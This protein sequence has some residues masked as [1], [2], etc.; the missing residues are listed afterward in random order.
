LEYV[1]IA[2]VTDFD[3]ARYRT[4]SLLGRV[5][6]VFLCDDGSFVVREA[7]CKHQG[8]DLGAGRLVGA[9]VTCPRHGWEYDL[10]TGECVNMS[11]LPLRSH[12]VKV[13]NGWIYVTMA[14]LEAEAPPEDDW[15]NLFTLKN[16]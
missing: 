1:K 16:P 5:V 8:A 14:P 3:R 13:E 9:R 12:G 10:C 7:R 2:P 4:Y 15:S 6:G 11:S